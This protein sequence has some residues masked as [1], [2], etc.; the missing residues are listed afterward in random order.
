VASW[1]ALKPNVRIGPGREPTFANAG[2]TW[3]V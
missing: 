3:L 1:S 2:G